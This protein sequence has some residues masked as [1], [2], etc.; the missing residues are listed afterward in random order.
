MIPPRGCFIIMAKS[1][2]AAIIQEVFRSRFRTGMTQVDFER[3]D[4][5]AAAAAGPFSAAMRRG[6]IEGLCFTAPSFREEEFSAAMRRGL[7]E[8]RP[9]RRSGRGTGAFSAAM[10]RGLIEGPAAGRMSR[11]TCNI[12]RGHA[13]RPH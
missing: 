2:Y 12:F 11:A 5:A 3:S 10:R 7:I 9:V 13:P 6:L 1:R 8:G 4:L